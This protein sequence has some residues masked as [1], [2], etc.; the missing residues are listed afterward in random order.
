VR[1]RY[2]RDPLFLVCIVGYFLNRWVLKR[3]WDGGFLHEHFNDLICIPFWV[4]IMLWMQRR[5][6]L[7]PR[8]DVPHAH[9]VVIPLLLWSVILTVA[10][11]PVFGWL[12]ARLG[13]RSGS[14]S[15][16]R[17]PLPR[18]T[19]RECRLAAGRGRW[20]RIPRARTPRVTR[21]DPAGSADR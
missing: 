15:M 5:L 7:R 1:F 13:G 11:Y 16:A 4:P 2:L 3:T 14:Q 17:W 21:R 19:A 20:S 6:G 10:F 18:G 12:R 8:D 9:E